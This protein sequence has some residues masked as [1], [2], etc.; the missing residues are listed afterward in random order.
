MVPLAVGDCGVRRLEIAGKCIDRGTGTRG[1][2]A[3]SPN[4]ECDWKW[5]EEGEE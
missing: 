2:G 5:A 1:L 4:L 3:V